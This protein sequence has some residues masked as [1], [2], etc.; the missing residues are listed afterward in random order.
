MQHIRTITPVLNESD[1]SHC[2]IFMS[3]RVCLLVKEELGVLLRFRRRG[4]L[5]FSWL[6][7][8]LSIYPYRNRLFVKK[9]VRKKM[10]SCKMIGQ[11]YKFFFNYGMIE[12]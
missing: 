8:A 4:R 2:R 11:K 9:S 3:V 6:S 1:C 5:F 12:A 7:D 10:K